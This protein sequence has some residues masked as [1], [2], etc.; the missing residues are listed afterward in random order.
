VANRLASHA[1][2]F[3]ADAGRTWLIAAIPATA[4]APP[5]KPSV[6]LVKMDT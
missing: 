5:L 2:E 4:T 1:Q 6:P 3:T